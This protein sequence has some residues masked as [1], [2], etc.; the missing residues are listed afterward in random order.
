MRS[1]WLLAAGLLSAG[2]ILAAAEP[3]CQWN[4]D[5]AD[6]RFPLHAAVQKDQGF[7]GNGALLDGKHSSELRFPQ[8]RNWTAFTFEM[9]FKLTEG[10]NR[11]AGNTL[12]CYC[13]HDWNR[14]QFLFRITPQSQLEAVFRQGKP[15]PEGQVSL[16]SKILEFEP[17]RWYTVRVAS[18]DDGLLKIWLNGELVGIREKGSWGFNRLE[19]E[20]PPRAT[21]FLLFFGRNAADPTVNYRPL[22]GIMDDIRVWD[23]FQEPGLLDETDAAAGVPL[24]SQNSPA[25]T[26]RFTVLDH[27]GEL[28]G[29]WVRPDQKFLDAAA[30][31]ELT[32][33]EADLIVRVVAP[34]AEGAALD[35]RPDATWT[36]DLIEIFIC[37]DPGKGL[38][39]Q[40][41]AN[42][43]GYKAAMAWT[44]PGTRQENFQSAGV[45][46]SEAFSDRWEA[47]FA[48]P[49]S[50]IGLE[51]DIEGKIVTA[52]FTRTGKSG[53]GQ[54]TWSPVGQDFHT[55]SKF[56]RIVFGSYEAA[57][58]KKL[59]ASRAEFQSIQGDPAEKRKIEAEL[60]A[61]EKSI[62][63]AQ[64]RGD[65]FV[66]LSDAIDRMSV[67]FTQLR[68]SGMTSLIWTPDLPWGND[69]TVSPISRPLEKLSLVLPQNSFT[70]AS[71][72]FTNL[73]EKPFLG[74]LKCFNRKRFD[75]KKVYNDFNSHFRTDPGPVHRNVT[76]FEALPIVSGDV[77][78]DP[79]LPLPLNTLVRAEPG[80]SKQL[81]M[82]FSSRDFEVGKHE[83]MLVLKPSNPGFAS[84]EIPVELEVKPVDLGTVKLDSFHYTFVNNDFLGGNGA[85]EDQ[86]R[87]LA[88]RDINVIYAG[89]LGSY[90]LD[91]YPETDPE[92][93]VIAY[94]DYG[95]W[96]RLIEAKVRAGV[97]KDR[98]KLLCWLE[99][100]TYGL[101]KK[102]KRLHDFNSP[103][104]RKAFHSWLHHFTGHMAEKHGIT[105][106]RIIFYT[107][108]E[109]GGD[110]ND[111]S[112]G[113]YKAW[114]CG[115]IIKEAGSDFRT[116]VNPY[117]DYLKRKEL[118]ALKKLADVYDIIEFYRPYVTDR[119]A[120]LARELGREIWTYGIYYKTTRP[121]IFRQE[122]WQ[123]LRDGF[124]SMIAYWHLESHAG[125][126]GFNSED[127]VRGRA[128]YGTTY[129]DMDSG[130]VLT[131]RRE[132]A[133]LLG[134]EDYKLAEFC[135]R[136][137]EKAP[138]PALRQELENII[139][140]GA[141]ADMEG[142]EQCRLKLLSLAEKLA[143]TKDKR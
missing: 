13:L 66:R 45:I 38:Y 8:A 31:A 43:S 92:G 127:G 51:G 81:W 86:V 56:R 128:D 80:Q 69:M 19:A 27:P 71:F 60:D 120:A 3:F 101:R 135:R 97:K 90:S 12:L 17:G 78:Y 42:V 55:P 23:S 61:L 112:S 25:K 141:S 104:W 102:G 53:G 50:E 40:Y 76:F 62:R 114:L 32:L 22:N 33:T 113:L 105:R 64:G 1:A 93:N 24:V 46:R 126:D 94:A 70:Y 143:Q 109:P 15:H 73:S 85:A 82:R 21:T 98:I 58:L 110:I 79:L 103:A 96:D 119:H 54:S 30:H 9:K 5:K 14:S 84:I 108:D 48:I 95:M 134:R 87:F 20:E 137:L 121:A 77:I 44:A 132:E 26:D 106:D 75:E 118:S 123:S 125:C 11:K 107:M 138:D 91:V 34:V 29:S 49:R 57:L 111:K 52:N 16:T 6:A 2:T 140:E 100:P 36:G 59:N 142:M 39:Y 129:M 72:V 28:P 4:F 37:P 130:T 115:Q 35:R 10:V 99:L 7:K 136:A 124:S 89:A 88:E 116:M 83:F 68:F 131:S 63:E 74:Q 117:P 65:L 47:E 67:R 133:H 139:R 41:A 122:Y 18:Q